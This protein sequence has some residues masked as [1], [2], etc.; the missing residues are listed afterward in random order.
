MS[1]YYDLTR[2]QRKDLIAGL[3]AAHGVSEATIMRV[4]KTVREKQKPRKRRADAG[5]SDVLPDDVLYRIAH[6][7]HQRPGKDGVTVQD[8]IDDA[9][10]QGWIDPENV[11]SASWVRARLIEKQIGVRQVRDNEKNAPAR[12]IEADHPNQRWQF[13]TTISQQFY[14]DEKSNIIQLYTHKNKPAPPDKARMALFLMVDDHSRVKMAKFYINDNKVNTMD[15]YTWCMLPKVDPSGNDA[16]AQFPCFGLPNDILTDKGPGIHAEFVTEK[17]ER[18]GIGL[19]THKK[20]LSKH[21]GKVERAI[22]VMQAFERL[23]TRTGKTKFK[24]IEEANV[25]LW[26]FLLVTNNTRH[27]VTGEK[28]F[29][30]WGRITSQQ[31]RLP[32]AEEDI[33]RALR[34]QKVERA[35]TK[36]RTFSIDGHTY[37]VPNRRPFVN[38]IGKDPMGN[39]KKVDV[40][41]VPN[42]YSEV[43]LLLENQQYII[44]E[45]KQ[46]PD[47]IDKPR[48]NAR[49]TTQRELDKIN[50]FAKN[51]GELRK[52]APDLQIQTRLGG[53]VPTYEENEGTPFDRSSFN[54]RDV[55]AVQK[56]YDYFDAVS[57]LQSMSL[58]SRPPTEAELALVKDCFG[59]GT[60]QIDE[61][62]FAELVDSYR[63]TPS[64][65][66]IKVV[67]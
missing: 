15:F 23:M 44:K 28:P 9:V 41:F 48:R 18:L 47:K 3:V 62:V 46:K 4:S 34:Y 49:T 56:M 51:F 19:K 55:Q 8:A 53:E 21:K 67:E 57:E 50:E 1:N 43:I 60:E 25:Y 31:L 13:D 6:L 24:D 2:Q 12:R 63:K 40:Y 64:A 66:A 10:G 61:N 38:Y 37:T 11:P 54:G 14:I 39:T 58:I 36:Y 29:E 27:S 45:G 7:V 17:L 42:D 33:I 32:P 30:R 16:R 20:T 65:A 59:G 35:I 26:N 52:P 22:Q 5:Q